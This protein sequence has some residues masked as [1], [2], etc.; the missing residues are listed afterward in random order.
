MANFK[1]IHFPVPELE[2]RIQNPTLES[3][4]QVPLDV[5]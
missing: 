4:V 5:E 2:Y 1:K 3:G